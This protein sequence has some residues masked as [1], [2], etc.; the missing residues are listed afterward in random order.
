[1]PSKM[2]RCLDLLGVEQGRRMYDD[3][4]YRA[5]YTY[6]VPLVDPGQAGSESTLFPPLVAEW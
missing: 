3:A 1:M 2:K 4:R 5:D 6:G